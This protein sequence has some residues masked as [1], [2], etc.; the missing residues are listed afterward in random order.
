VLALSENAG[1]QQPTG[2]RNSPRRACPKGS[3]ARSTRGEVDGLYPPLIKTVGERPGNRGQRAPLTRASAEAPPVSVPGLTPLRPKTPPTGRD[4]G[5]LGGKCTPRG[6]RPRAAGTPDSHQTVP[7]GATGGRSDP[8]AT[9][10]GPANADGAIGLVVIFSLRWS[11]PLSRNTTLRR[12]PTRERSRSYGH[13][14]VCGRWRRAQLFQKAQS[15]P[16]VVRDWKSKDRNVRSNRRSS[17]V[18]QFTCRRAISCVLHRSTRRL[19]H[20]SGL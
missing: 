19:I 18:L 1:D 15:Q 13:G 8:G 9:A 20:R 5:N 14:T 7:C 3:D 2:A 4:V 11:I 6:F 16:G 10:R 17:C 12:A